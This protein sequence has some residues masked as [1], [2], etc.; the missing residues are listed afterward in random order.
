MRKREGEAQSC[1]EEGKEELERSR[2]I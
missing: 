2:E 1:R